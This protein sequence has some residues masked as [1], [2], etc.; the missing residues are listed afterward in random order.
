MN[1]SCFFRWLR[2][3]PSATRAEEAL[4]DPPATASNRTDICAGGAEATAWRSPEDVARGRP[5]SRV[6]LQRGGLCGGTEER[7]G[8]AGRCGGGAEEKEARGEETANCR[9]GASQPPVG[10]GAG[11][12]VLGA[13]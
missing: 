13:S 8:A 5:R 11:G 3:P 10:D 12:G 4:L 6:G 2:W 1:L 9:V 7:D